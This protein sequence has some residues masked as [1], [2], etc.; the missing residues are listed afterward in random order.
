MFQIQTRDSQY[1]QLLSYDTT[2]KLGDFY[3]SPLL[4]RNLFKKS[5]VMPSLLMNH[6]RKLK[7]T[8]DELMRVVAQLLPSLVNGAHTLPLVTDDEKG[9][10]AIDDHLHKVCRL[11]CW[12]HILN[13]SKTWL[14]SHGTTSS[15]IPVYV[16]NLRNLLHQPSEE[17]YLKLLKEL[18]NSWSQPFIKYYMSEIHS[19]VIR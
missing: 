1:S 19:K 7:S 3:V 8:H 2:F 18:K 4:F 10:H 16:Y 12:N 15:E 9:F 6:E 14:R 11:Y 5:A 17:E 13:A